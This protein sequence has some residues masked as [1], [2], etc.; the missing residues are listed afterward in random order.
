MFWMQFVEVSDEFFGYFVVEVLKVRVVEGVEGQDG[1]Y[2][3]FIVGGVIVGFM[4][5]C[6]GFIV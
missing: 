3:F 4:L 6:G 1:E 5:I 2:D